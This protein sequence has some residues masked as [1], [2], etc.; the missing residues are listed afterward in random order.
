[1]NTDNKLIFEAF[2]ESVSEKAYIMISYSDR[3]MSQSKIT[4]VLSRQLPKILTHGAIEILGDLDD[5]DVYEPDETSFKEAVKLAV[6][7]KILFTFSGGDDIIYVFH[8]LKSVYDSLISGIGINEKTADLIMQRLIDDNAVDYFYYG[9]GNHFRKPAHA[10]FYKTSA[11][12]QDWYE[13]NSVNEVGQIIGTTLSDAFGSRDFEQPEDPNRE[14]PDE[15]VDS[16]SN[17]DD[18]DE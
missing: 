9:K 16:F 5:V 10:V 13:V 3:G 15:Y 7:E 1:M 18:D 4:T 14:G 6:K 2:L 8:D 17:D 11:N 12:P